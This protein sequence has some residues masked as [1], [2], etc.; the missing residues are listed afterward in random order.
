MRRSPEVVVHPDL[1]DVRLH[2]GDAI[3]FLSRGLRSRRR[4]D[5]A[6]HEDPRA[7]ETGLILAVAQREAGGP[8]ASQAHDGRH[9][10]ARIAAKLRDEVRLG[11]ELRAALETLRVGH[12]AVRVHEAWNDG[13]ARQIDRLGARRHGRRRAGRDDTAVTDD[14]NALVGDDLAVAVDQ[15]R[16]SK[17]RRAA[18]GTALPGGCLRDGRDA[19]DQRRERNHDELRRT[20]EHDESVPHFG[21]SR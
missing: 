18:G 9:A 21:G 16:I 20:A 10:I 13:A 4:D 14:E 7:V 8:V 6:G 12:V 11:V 2:G 15:P 3:D 19:C 17:R 1:D 5:G